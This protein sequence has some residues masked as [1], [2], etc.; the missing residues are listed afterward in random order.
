MRTF[1]QQHNYEKL[2]Q[3]S[4]QIQELVRLGV[5]WLWQTVIDFLH[6][7]SGEP[8]VKQKI[9]RVGNIY[10]RVYDPVSDRT[11]RFND[12]QEVMIW[13]DERHYRRAH[14]HLWNIS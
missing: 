5:W 14:S 3:L 12:K 6:T 11:V 7:P 2:E 10:W 8:E 1:Q 4:P 9:D 13:L